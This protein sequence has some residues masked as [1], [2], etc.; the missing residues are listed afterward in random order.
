MITYFEGTVGTGDVMFV[1]GEYGGGL[2]KVWNKIT[3]K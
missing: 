1:C 2:V 3:Q